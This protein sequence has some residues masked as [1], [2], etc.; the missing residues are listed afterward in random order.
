[1]L[2]RAGV[3][4]DFAYSDAGRRQLMPFAVICR[5]TPPLVNAT[6]ELDPTADRETI[7]H[8]GHLEA[9]AIVSL[10]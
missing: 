10:S 7:E 3:S 4:S 1:M 5:Q 2:A 6:N 9:F 8:I